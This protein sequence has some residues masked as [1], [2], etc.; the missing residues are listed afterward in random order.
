MCLFGWV[1]LVVGKNGFW[2]CVGIQ[3]RGGWLPTSLE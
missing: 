2:V 3:G 1:V